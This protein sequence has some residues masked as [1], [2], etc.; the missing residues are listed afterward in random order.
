MHSSLNDSSTGEQLLMAVKDHRHTATSFAEESAH[1]IL[2]QIMDFT[3]LY[4]RA[5]MRN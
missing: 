1:Q 4:S 2:D 5:S 3:N